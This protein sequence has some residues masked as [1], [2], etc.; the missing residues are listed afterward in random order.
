MAPEKLVT[1]CMESA[2]S[3]LKPSK[4]SAVQKFRLY[5]TKLMDM[6][7]LN[8]IG[9]KEVIEEIKVRPNFRL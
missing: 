2:I 9:T 7:R 8:S 5:Q 1:K 4:S 6:D 3:S